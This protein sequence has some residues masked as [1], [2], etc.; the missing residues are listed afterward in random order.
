MVSSPKT[1]RIWEFPDEGCPGRILIAVLMRDQFVW[2][3][4]ELQ[5]MILEEGIGIHPQYYHGGIQVPCMPVY[6]ETPRVQ[7]SVREG[8][9][10]RDAED[11]EGKG[12]SILGGWKST[13]VGG[14]FQVSRKSAGVRQGITSTTL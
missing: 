9:R 7:I 8:W 14:T 2:Q 5:V 12:D 3:K 4:W 13:I 1:L 6:I 11:F 10:R